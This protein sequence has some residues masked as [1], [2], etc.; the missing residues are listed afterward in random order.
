VWAYFFGLGLID[1]VD[2]PEHNPPSHPEVLKALTD[3]F[4]ASG[5]DLRYL[6][7]TIT[8]TRLYQLT[9]A[10]S[11]ASQDTPRECARMAPR[12][13][14]PEQFFDSLALATGFIDTTPPRQRGVPGVRTPRNDFLAKFANQSERRTEPELSVVQALVLMNGQFVTD[15]TGI[16]NSRTLAAVLEAPKLTT[17]ERI[18]ALFVATL[19]RKPRPEE[20]AKYLKYVE[21]GG[22]SGDAKR[23]LADVFWVLLNSAEFGL[24]H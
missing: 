22:P 23:A 15:A 6:F 3:A 18:E 1:P 17:A 5:Y 12:G 7:R 2:E 4:V 21:R 16:E 24:N 20:A 19:S 8:A 14:S 11:D 9:S 13:L 10:R